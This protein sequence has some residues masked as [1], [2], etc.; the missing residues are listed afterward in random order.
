MHVVVIGGTGH[1]G[2]YLSPAPIESGHRVTC[3][4]R[5]ERRPCQPHDAWNQIAQVTLD[6]TLEESHNTFGARIARYTL[7][8]ARQLVDVLRDLVTLS[9]GFQGGSPWVSLVA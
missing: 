6:R 2:T 7:D 4:T 9:T 1:I 5:G 8:S 3:V